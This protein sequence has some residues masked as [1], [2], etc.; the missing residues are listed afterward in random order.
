MEFKK[1]I[2]FL[3]IL[4]L[5][6]TL[7][8]KVNAEETSI[9]NSTPEEVANDVKSRAVEIDFSAIA[10]NYNNSIYTKNLK[11]LGINIKA[12]QSGNNV[13]LTYND[14]DTVTFTLNPDTNVLTAIYPLA[15]KEKK[16]ILAAI[17]V[18]TV[19]SMQGN[20]VGDQLPFYFNDGFCYSY[21]QTNGIAKEY[22]SSEEGVACVSC[23]IKLNLRMSIPSDNSPILESTFLIDAN[24]IYS[25][26]E[27][28]SR[29]NGLIFYKTFSDDNKLTLYI[30]QTKGFD[31]YAYDS[32]LNF[33]SLIYNHMNFNTPKVLLYMR[34]NYSGFENGNAEFDGVIIDTGITDFPI[35]NQETILVGN[36]MKYAKLTIDV[37]LLKERAAEVSLVSTSNSNPP[38]NTGRTKVAAGLVILLIALVVI[39]IIYDKKNK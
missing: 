38:K 1:I 28:F 13:L 10:D 39:K 12:T 35:N 7:C 6:L 31:K 8:L 11:E 27:Y 30:G 15:D 14:S 20:E 22:I 32:V 37:D 18:D 16:D 19:S 21:V 4:F 17:M 29:E 23:E 5:L 3:L 36:K 34:Q 25:K 26:N 2:I 24:N 33:L 9:Y